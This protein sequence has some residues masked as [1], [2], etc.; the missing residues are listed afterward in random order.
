MMTIPWNLVADIAAIS[1]GVIGL[2]YAMYVSQQ[3][4]EFKRAQMKRLH[5]LDAQLQAVGQGSIGMGKRVLLL[6]D[7]IKQVG[8]RLQ[9]QERNSPD[10]IPYNEASRLMEMGASID[11]IVSACGISRAEAELVS[12]LRKQK[13]AKN[14]VEVSV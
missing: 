2:G 1:I 3:L 12:V 5:D 7:S 11:D 8:V 6:E 13:E 4:R 9:E 10:R 14:A